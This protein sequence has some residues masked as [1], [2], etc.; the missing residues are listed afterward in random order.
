LS[1]LKI[2]NAGWLIDGSENSIRPQVQIRVRS[3]RIDAIHKNWPAPS[4]NNPDNSDIATLDL[5]NATI[6]PVLV[7]SH[8]HLSMSGTM[9]AAERLRQLDTEFDPAKENFRFGI[10]DFRFRILIRKTFDWGFGIVDFGF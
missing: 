8:V 9:D 4:G 2:I 10:W 5:K 6:L 1:R 3:G 7:D